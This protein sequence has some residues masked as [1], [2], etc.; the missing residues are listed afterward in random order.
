MK[1][2]NTDQEKLFAKHICDKVLANNIQKSDYSIL[3]TQ[4][5]Q[6]KHDQRF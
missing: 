6:S 4:T 3:R 5:T 1:R 2:Q